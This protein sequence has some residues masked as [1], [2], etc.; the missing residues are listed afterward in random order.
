MK[1]TKF[2]YVYFSVHISLSF[3]SY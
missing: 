3:M 2:T 1:V